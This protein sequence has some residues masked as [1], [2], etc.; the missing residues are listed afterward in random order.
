M[1][2]R[3]Q[4]EPRVVNTGS[5]SNGLWGS[6]FD[7]GNLIA[8]KLRELSLMQKKKLKDMHEDKGLQGSSVIA[9][10][11]SSKRLMHAEEAENLVK[12]W[13]TIKAEALGP[14]YQVH[15]LV[16]VLDE[17]MLL[18]VSN[19]LPSF[20]Q[21]KVLKDVWIHVLANS[22]FSRNKIRESVVLIRIVGDSICMWL[23]LSEVVTISYNKMGCSG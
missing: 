7:K 10:S 5:L 21:K 19:V 3:A 9:S 11:V 12:Q 15:N 14:N 4:G 8:E 1:S 13:Q 22:L 16:D 17:P 2:S 18:Q 23:L 6:A 20:S